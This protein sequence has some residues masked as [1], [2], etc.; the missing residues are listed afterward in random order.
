MFSLPR[1]PF[2]AGER[3]LSQYCNIVVTM[4][5]TSACCYFRYIIVPHTTPSY[6]LLLLAMPLMSALESV[7]RTVFELHLMWMTFNLLNLIGESSSISSIDSKAFP[8]GE[9]SNIGKQK[10]KQ[11]SE[12]MSCDYRL[13]ILEQDC[14]CIIVMPETS[15]TMLIAPAKDMSAY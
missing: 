7:F 11:L 15:A 2:S 8:H 12:S 5:T 13:K 4:T 3:L 9:D 10:P 6:Q 14:R 1:C